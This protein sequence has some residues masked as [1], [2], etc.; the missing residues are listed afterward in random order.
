M[1]EGT[2][3]QVSEP[4]RLRRCGA[5]DHLQKNR[6]GRWTVSRK[7]IGIID[8]TLREG[9]QTPGIAFTDADRLSIIRGLCRVGVD[10]I[11]LGVAS[12]ANNYLRE[13]FYN[14]RRITRGGCRLGIWSRCKSE[15]IIFAAACKPDVI[16]ISIPVSDL[17]ISKR[18]QKNRAW[19][20]HILAV[21]IRQ[22]L[23]LDI[24]YISVG[25]E[26]ASRAD[27]D[28]LLQI[29]QTAE[30]N[31]ARRVRLADTVG[32]CTPGGIQQLVDLVKKK[33]GMEIGVH[34]HNDFGMAT[35]NSIAAIESGAGWLDATVLGLGERAGNCRLEEVT[36]Y[37][38]LIR[39]DRRYQPQ[40][41]ANLC[42]FVAGVTG[43]EIPENHP[44]VGNRIFTCETGLHQHGLSVI[45]ETYEPYEPQ[46]VGTERTLRFGPKTG[47]RA[48]N[49]QLIK[50]GLH[51]DDL[52]IRSLADLIRARECAFNEEQLFRFALRNMQALPTGN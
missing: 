14:A 39:N 31:G 45:P 48:I 40:R 49:L 21:S 46:R 37:M 32:T 34:C 38:A 29:A 23:A 13:L 2:T 20:K 52:Q 51:L 22:A 27:P 11:E 1:R 28:F 42:R 43:R 35:A 26:D 17:H 8:S 47:T 5:C 7:F 4:A 12:P 33:V 30:E 6:P 44:I 25:L 50:N 24:P 36:G 3:V 19:I 18:L 16:S 41:L 15:D 9:E 10:E